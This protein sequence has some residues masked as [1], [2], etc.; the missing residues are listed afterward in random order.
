MVNAILC[1]LPMI[2][3]LYIEHHMVGV[4]EHV[5]TCI[6]KLEMMSG[7]TCI[8]GLVGMGGVGKTCLAKE[9]YNYFGGAKKFQAMSFLEIDR[10][11][12]SSMEVGQSLVKRL[13]EQL[14]WNLSQVPNN[15]QQRYKYWFNRLSTQGAVLVVLDDI[16]ER[17]QFDE[18][19]FDKSLLASGSCVIVTSRD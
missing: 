14:L 6:N 18:V 9:I 17:S 11:S 7:A 1:K 16:Y 3:E 8:L 19:I 10:H 15:N 2:Q 5:R 13:Q 4:E 12:T